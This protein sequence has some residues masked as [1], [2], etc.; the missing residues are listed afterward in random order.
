MVLMSAARTRVI[1]PR[2]GIYFGIFTSV[3][4]ALAL[5]LM[6]LE[7]LGV[8]DGTLSVLMLF[9]SVMLYA[10]IGLFAFTRDPM[11]YFAAG[12]RVPAF[13]TGL[14]LSMSSIGWI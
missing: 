8:A 11:D 13:Y 1:N 5:V 7:Q 4:V 12:R 14:G 9:G 6:I 2:L 3:L 10:S